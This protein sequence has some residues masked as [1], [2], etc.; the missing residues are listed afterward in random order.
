MSVRDEIAVQEREVK[1]FKLIIDKLK[2]AR[3]A[4]LFINRYRLLDLPVTEAIEEAIDMLREQ[5][6]IIDELV[7]ELNSGKSKISIDK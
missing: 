1:A 2:R 5:E 4:I 7:D 6:D 3:E